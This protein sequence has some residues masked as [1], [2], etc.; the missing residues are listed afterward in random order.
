MNKIVA[1]KRRASKTRHKQK[2]LGIIRLVVTR[3][4]K[5]INAQII[6][7][8]INSSKVLACASSIEKD[9]R[10]KSDL[11]K[12]D[13]AKLVGQRIAERAKEIGVDTMAF[14]RSG[15]RYHGRVKAL[16]DAAREGGMN[17]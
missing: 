8:E 4:N 14:D 1:R 13:L 10:E 12:V 3:S 6:K 2:E 11:S 5:H 9:V 15:N 16:A 17:F 7:P